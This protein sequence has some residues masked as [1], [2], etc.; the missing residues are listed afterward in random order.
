ML[1]VT[2][3]LTGE[4]V[5]LPLR[6]ILRIVNRPEGP[7]VLYRCVC[8]ALGEWETGEAG[9]TGGRHSPALDE[10]GAVTGG[11]RQHSGKGQTGD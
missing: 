2:C 11:D 10:S 1:G 3:E 6:S 8:G 9:R 5:L 4:R 7:L